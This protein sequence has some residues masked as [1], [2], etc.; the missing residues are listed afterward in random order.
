[1]EGAPTPAAQ[2]TL[3]DRQHFDLTGFA[4]VKAEIVGGT[5]ERNDGL[6]AIAVFSVLGQG[7]GEFWHV[8][9][10]KDTCR[11]ARVFRAALPNASR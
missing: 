4:A 6:F 1:M 10:Q 7:R 8:K 5:G 11:F 2:S 9:L 3:I